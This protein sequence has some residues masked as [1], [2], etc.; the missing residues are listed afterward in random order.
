MLEGNTPRRRGCRDDVFLGGGTKGGQCPGG[1]AKFRRGCNP[2]FMDEFEVY[3]RSCGSFFE[4]SYQN[5]HR[6]HVA[7][8]L[9]EALPLGF[10]L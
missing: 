10:Y 3:A 7:R 9:A 8:G 2:P 6:R 1:T 4:N 5:L